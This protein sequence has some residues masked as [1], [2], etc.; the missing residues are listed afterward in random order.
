VG[1]FDHADEVAER[2]AH[3]G[4]A[5]A[6]ADVGYGRLERGAG[7][8]QTRDFGIDVRRAPV[9]GGAGGAGLAVGNQAQLEAADREADV[10]RLLENAATPSTRRDTRRCAILESWPLSIGKGNLLTVSEIA[11]IV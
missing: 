11:L 10:E 7:A 2:V 5:D 1:I 3:A 6:V 4:R 9:G 8:G